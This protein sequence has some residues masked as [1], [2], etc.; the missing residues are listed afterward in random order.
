MRRGKFY[1]QKP[2]CPAAKLNCISV[3]DSHSLCA[4][5]NR[6]VGILEDW[7]LPVERNVQT[8]AFHCFEKEIAKGTEAH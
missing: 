1:L 5:A 8:W 3:T 6:Y 4:P 7:T 2:P